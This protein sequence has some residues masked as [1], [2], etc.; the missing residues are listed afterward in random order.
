MTI[1]ASDAIAKSSSVKLSSCDLSY[2]LDSADRLAA[3]VG[4]LKIKGTQ[5]RYHVTLKDNVVHLFP[6]IVDGV[7]P[8]FSKPKNGIAIDKGFG[9]EWNRDGID[10]VIF[11]KEGLIEDPLVV[12][13]DATI[14]GRIVKI[15]PQLKEFKELSK[16]EEL[17]AEEKL[18]M[19][20][21]VRQIQDAFKDK[22]N[23]EVSELTLRQKRDEELRRAREVQEAINRSAS[24][25][26]SKITRE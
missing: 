23:D 18:R 17:T 13:P 19:A 2:E 5:G 25:G 7:T 24:S 11:Y 16:K 1:Q 4:Q 26:A 6:V 14:S 22:D 9:I 8:T 12:S 15:A 3:V 21:L 20:S 10:G